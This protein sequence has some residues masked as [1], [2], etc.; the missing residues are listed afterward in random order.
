M[1]NLPISGGASTPTMESIWY[2]R[3]LLNDNPESNSP[4]QLSKIVAQTTGHTHKFH[5]GIHYDIQEM[6]QYYLPHMRN[7]MQGTPSL[8]K[9]PDSDRGE[10][11]NCLDTVFSSKSGELHTL[12]IKAYAPRGFKFGLL[13][14]LQVTQAKGV[15]FTSYVITDSPTFDT[16]TMPTPL[17]RYNSSY[18]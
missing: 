4:F 8:L 16:T 12:A 6:L 10:V 5:P 14:L 13:T 17:N 18:C 2:V 15:G 3:M 11:N 9:V 1:G 7:L